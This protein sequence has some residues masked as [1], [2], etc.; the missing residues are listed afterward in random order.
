MCTNI[1]MCIIYVMEK[2]GTSI[3][4]NIG[5][6]PILLPKTHNTPVQQKKH[7]PL[8]KDVTFLCPIVL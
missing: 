8:A 6:R 7:S 2:G 4:H 5:R 1:C 3:S